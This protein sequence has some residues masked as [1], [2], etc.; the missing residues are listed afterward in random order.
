MRSH[1][2][3]TAST[4]VATPSSSSSSSS[5]YPIAAEIGITGSPATSPD[6]ERLVRSDNNNGDGESVNTNSDNG[7]WTRVASTSSL[8]GLEM[9]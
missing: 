7:A 8:D 3:S 4:S 6:D 9:V 2:A 1:L 5:P